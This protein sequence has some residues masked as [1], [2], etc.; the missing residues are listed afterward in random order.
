VPNDRPLD[1]QE[2]EAVARALWAAEW[3][4]SPEELRAEPPTDEDPD[5]GW[6][7][8]DTWDAIRDQ[9][10]T[11]VAA[12][13]ARASQAPEPE[14]GAPEA[15]SEANRK[16]ALDMGRQAPESDASESVRW[17]DLAS[18][19]AHKLE[20]RGRGADRTQV[21]V[22]A[23]DIDKALA[24]FSTDEGPGPD[25]RRACKVGAESIAAMGIGVDDEPVDAD[26]AEAIEALQVL[27]R[28]AARDEGSE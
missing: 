10:R 23:H 22:L 24:G 3:K 14:S 16:Q 4:K 26:H 7:V 1:P 17:L 20:A 28:L 5:P 9:A 25:E 15:Q 21:H 11:A 13:S 27:R 8:D 19:L 2:V 6:W 12:L 18:D